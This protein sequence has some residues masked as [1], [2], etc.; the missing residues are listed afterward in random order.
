[1]AEKVEIGELK[2]EQHELAKRVVVNN[3]LNKVKLIAGAEVVALEDNRLLA[4]IAVLDASTLQLIDSAIA[5]E[6]A[7]MKYIPG[8]QGFRENPAIV[9]AYVKL[10]EKPDILMIKGHGIAHPLRVGMA[11]Q[12]GLQLNQ[13][14][15]G[16]ALKPLCGKVVDGKLIID[17]EHR[18]TEVRT[19]E[20]SNPV[21]V[22]PG[23]L[24]SMNQAVE[25]VKRTILHPH[26][27]PEPLFVARRLASKHKK[28]NNL[29]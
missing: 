2:R 25:L 7:P 3:K 1:M 22:S 29:K 26:K 23:H 11:S 6:Q 8:F 17:G 27:L 5:E 12:L 18:G 19:R 14:T 10:K 24:T 28:S 20:Y 4:C 9:V 13:P 16:V 21:L 15:I